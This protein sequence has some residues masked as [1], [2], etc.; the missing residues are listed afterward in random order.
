MEPL[1]LHR[2]NMLKVKGATSADSPRTLLGLPT[3]LR[4]HV[5]DLVFSSTTI[6]AE[7]GPVVVDPNPIKLDLSMIKVDNPI[8]QPVRTIKQRSKT[9]FSVVTSKVLPL[10]GS[11]CCLEQLVAVEI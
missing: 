9:F 8:F 1:N 3:E 10:L 7:R 5:F 4:Q 11:L 2:S 6:Y